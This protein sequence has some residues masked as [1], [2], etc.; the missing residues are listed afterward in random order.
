MGKGKVEGMDF[1]SP[2]HISLNLKIICPLAIAK[3]CYWF[4]AINLPRHWKKKKEHHCSN[5]ITLKIKR[6]ISKI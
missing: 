4:E 3:S 2:T 1:Y 5:E 6:W